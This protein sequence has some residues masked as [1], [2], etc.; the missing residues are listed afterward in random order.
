[1]RQ[2][3]YSSDTD[4]PGV[5]ARSHMLTERIGRLMAIV[6]GLNANMDLVALSPATFVPIARVRLVL[7]D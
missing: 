5:R 6:G 1:M 7:K 3:L 2:P 4:N